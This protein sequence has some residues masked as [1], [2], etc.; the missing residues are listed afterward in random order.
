MSGTSRALRVRRLPAVSLG[1]GGFLLCASAA[2][3]AA[4]PA[5]PSLITAASGAV[6]VG[7][8]VF[9]TAAVVGGASPTGTVTFRLFFGEGAGDTACVNRPAFASTNAVGGAAATSSPYTPTFG[10][11]FRWTATYSG[12]ANNA[13]A[14]TA[15]NDAHESVE[16]RRA[17]PTLTTRTSAASVAAGAQITDTATISGSFDGSFVPCDILMPAAPGLTC[18]DS[19]PPPPQVVFALYGPD[20]ARCTTAPVFTSRAT[21]PGAFTLGSVSANGAYGSGPFRP[22]RPGTYRWAAASI[23][24]AGNDPAIS[25]CNSPNETVTVKAPV[26]TGLKISPNAF[27]AAAS[28]PSIAIASSGVVSYRLSEAGLV[29]F[30]IEKAVSGGVAG[31]QCARLKHPVLGA[32][33]CTRFVTLPGSFGRSSQAGVNE[34]RYRGR[35]HG[36]SLVAGRY[37][38]V[39]RANDATGNTT[40]SKRAGFRILQP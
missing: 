36:R 8:V 15:C 2:A 27:A 14:A 5:Q 30:T 25:A 16:V 28:G 35:L 10:G 4:G 26:L 22:T 38:L 13:P 11:T 21:P 24:D 12:D 40:P 17:S 39:A 6:G 18:A 32:K 3:S 1:V 37:R 23:G 31:G 9:D 7:G 33:R 20:D 29:T 19:A 34:L